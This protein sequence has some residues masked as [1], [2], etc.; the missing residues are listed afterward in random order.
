MSESTEVDVVE[1]VATDEAREAVVSM[2]RDELGDAV[3]ETHVLAGIDLWVRVTAD[4]WVQ[5]HE[6][7]KARGFE[8][9]D[10]VSAI[11][12]MPS[13]FG[14]EMDAEVD[15]IVHGSE[16]KEAEAM[17]SGVA[18]GDTRLQMLSRVFNIE[19]N[20]GITF[21]CDLDDANPAVGTLIG[22]YAGAN[23]HE[24][25]VWEMFGVTING[26]PDLRALY[27]PT[28]F[29][30]NPLRKDYPLLARRVKPWPGI[31]DVEPMPGDG[32]DGEGEES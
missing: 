9:F 20:I 31:V 24:R 8:F 18:G 5:A 14:R 26:H 17:A 12:W 10:F 16:P 22:V 32:D 11:D 6:L 2:L 15:T 23:W 7:A 4:A 13:P 30:G 27:L 29:E 1:E 25:E 28:G 3:V 21:K 19:T